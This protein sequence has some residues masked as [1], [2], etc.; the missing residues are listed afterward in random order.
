MI[1]SRG[2]GYQR[3]KKPL[4][5]W[6]TL[7]II[8]GIIVLGVP[9]SMGLS[10]LMPGNDFDH[11]SRILEKDAAAARAA[12]VP[13]VASDID[14][15]KKVD[16]ADNAAPLILD[17]YK[18]LKG[19]TEFSEE[20]A[21]DDMSRG[22]WKSAEI[23]IAKVAP[24]LTAAHE[25]ASKTDCD[26]QLDRDLGPSLLLP[27]LAGARNL[28]RTLA[29]RAVIEAHRGEHGK[30][31]AD[32][33]AASKIGGFLET[34]DLI[35]SS[36]VHSAMESFVTIGAERCM[37]F[38]KTPEELKL[39][40]DVLSEPRKIPDILQ[41]LRTECYSA[42][43]IFRNADAYGDLDKVFN[44]DEM[45]S[46]NAKGVTSAT[47]KRSGFPDDT[48]ARAYMA[49]HF[50]VWTTIITRARGLK[51]SDAVL[52]MADQ[53]IRETT[54]EKGKSFRLENMASPVFIG[55]GKAF[56]TMD[57]RWNVKTALAKVL[58]YHA[59]HAAYPKTLSEAGVTEI[60]PFDGKPL[61]YIVSKE[62][63]TVYSIGRDGVDDGGKRQTSSNKPNDE[64]A[65]FPPPPIR[66][67]LPT[68]KQYPYPTQNAKPTKAVH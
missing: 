13:V 5:F 60:D 27:E 3:E 28:A 68:R 64:V 49:R 25:A 18:K 21:V 24:A 40:L 43:T 63:V 62:G 58:L 47:V 17:A 30:A 41:I 2:H 4:S 52:K 26:F 15:G 59:D 33:R 12:G 23:E 66:S 50:E 38:A 16:L 6:S 45:S 42:T 61:K 48:K 56:T 67:P 1:D 39:Y 10:K 37:S 20:Q 65:S 54:M 53:V 7:G 55:A 29:D 11:A 19:A 34:E 35:I 31:A 22:D 57:A 36:L 32:L 51:D 46:S 8:V 14:N 9:V 44:Y